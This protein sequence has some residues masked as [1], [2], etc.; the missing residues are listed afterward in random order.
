M[1]SQTKRFIEFLD[2]IG[3][4]VE[5]K[6]CGIS[7]LVSGDALTSLIDPHNSTL[8]I[9]PTCANPWTI[10]NLYPQRGFDTEVKDFIRKLGKMRELEEQLGCK[11][12]FEIKDEVCGEK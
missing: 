8:S 4:Q 6:K 12:R 3:I 1:T 2:I 7:L 10:P 11:L 5:C 9:C